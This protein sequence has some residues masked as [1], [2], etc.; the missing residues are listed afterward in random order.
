[1]IFRRLKA[2]IGAFLKGNRGSITPAF[3]QGQSQTLELSSDVGK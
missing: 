1:M 3:A 2:E